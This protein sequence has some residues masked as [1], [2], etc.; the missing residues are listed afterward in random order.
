MNRIGEFI[1]ISWTTPVEEQN[2]ENS[3]RK[4][5]EQLF[6]NYGKRYNNTVDATVILRSDVYQKIQEIAERCPQCF[7]PFVEFL[8]SL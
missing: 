5:V 8:E 4:I 7:K 3:P 2:H 6:K 1:P